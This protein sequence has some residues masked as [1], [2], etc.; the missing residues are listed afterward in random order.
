MTQDQQEAYM[1]DA[2]F[3]LGTT[4][5]TLTVDRCRHETVTE[6]ALWIFETVRDNPGRTPAKFRRSQVGTV[7]HLDTTSDLKW[8]A[9]RMMGGSPTARRNFPTMRGALDWIET[10]E[11]GRRRA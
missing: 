9:T 7:A 11:H 6:T 4:G 1:K 5:S 3:I 8:E 10:Y 2:A